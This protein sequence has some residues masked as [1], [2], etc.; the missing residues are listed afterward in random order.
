MKYYFFIVFKIFTIMAFAQDVKIVEKFD[1]LKT[2]AIPDYSKSANW[3]ALPFK[4][5]A[6][7]TFIGLNNYISL[8]ENLGVDV[9]FIHPTTF[10]YKP[11]G[12]NLW[13]GDVNND[14]LNNKTNNSTIRYQA[15][16]FNSSGNVYAPYYR[17]A[18]YYSYFTPD[19]FSA[20]MALDIAYSDVKQAFEYYLKNYNEGKPIL[21]AA[22]S[23]GTTHGIRL[24]KDFFDEKALMGQ[25]VCA[26]LV[27][28]P[29]YDT[30][31][32]DLK[33][34]QN[35]NQ[36]GCYCTWRTYAA[37]YYP[38]K[39]KKPST[40]SICTNP[41]TWKTDEAYA[42]AK[43]NKGGVLRNM[44]TV[45]PGLCDAQIGDGVLRINKP[46]FRGSILLHIKN[47]HIGD[48][49]LFYTNVR[50][51]AELRVKQFKKP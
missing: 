14:L 9:F 31:F 16:V 23:Q 51:N 47:Y 24:L 12:S 17:Q 15:S 13:N 7:D 34:C 2:P 44:Q 27:G 42:S 43:L 26:Y 25:L 38:K 3:A 50:E 4:K 10:T 35:E 41:L 45:I 28:M 33:P 5:D 39:Y 46:N 30:L 40:F 8:K 1:S 21:I 22:H 49:N 20:R 32:I 19:T 6:A 36:T 18:H 29:V 37:G 48:Y 11:T